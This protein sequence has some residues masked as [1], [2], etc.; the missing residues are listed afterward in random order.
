MWKYVINLRKT[1]HL[2]SILST[3]LSNIL[4]GFFWWSLILPV[5]Q[6][7][8]WGYLWLKLYTCSIKTF[9]LHTLHKCKTVNYSLQLFLLAIDVSRPLHLIHMFW[10]CPAIYFCCCLYFLLF[11]IFVFLYICY[12]SLLLLICI[13]I[14]PFVHLN[15]CSPV[16]SVCLHCIWASAHPYLS[17]ANSGFSKICGFSRSSKVSFEFPLLYWFKC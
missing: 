13:I 7:G 10:S 17:N 8:K 6:C 9:T 14:Q 12:F 3:M 11:F 16:T 2:S 5:S 4:K 15:S 1:N